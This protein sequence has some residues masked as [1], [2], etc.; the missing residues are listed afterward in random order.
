MP[1]VLALDPVLVDPQAMGVTLTAGE[2][3]RSG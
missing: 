2:L 1:A 3:R